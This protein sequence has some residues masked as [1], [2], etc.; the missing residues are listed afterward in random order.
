MSAR[1]FA[2]GELLLVRCSRYSLP[3]SVCS[4]C[5]I[6]MIACF[7]GFLI[8][9]LVYTC[10]QYQC[11]Y[12]CAYLSPGCLDWIAMGLRP[13]QSSIDEHVADS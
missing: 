4:A 13:W 5:A 8:L 11:T 6:L 7:G 3:C 12:V 2:L 10:M 9:A 1:T